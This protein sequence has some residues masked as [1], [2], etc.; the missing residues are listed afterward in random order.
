MP[1]TTAA[2]CTQSY[3][4][5]RS[6]PAKTR[7]ANDSSLFA[8]GASC[9]HYYQD[10]SVFITMRVCR[11]YGNDKVD[12]NEA[13]DMRL[14][15]GHGLV[16]QSNFV[17]MISSCSG[18]QKRRYKSMHPSM[19]SSIVMCV[20]LFMRRTHAESYVH[21]VRIMHCCSVFTPSLLQTCIDSVA[22]P[23]GRTNLV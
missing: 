13:S 8:H 23:P 11:L 7:S 4:H 21:T 12:C 15:L 14:C 1:F 10:I 16:F 18:Q 6:L 2:P 19:V 17:K 20:V 5:T 9:Q 22:Y 3:K